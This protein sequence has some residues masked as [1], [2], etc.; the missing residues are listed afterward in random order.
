MSTNYQDAPE[1]EAEYRHMESVGQ[2]EYQKVRTNESM[3]EQQEYNIYGQE[4]KDC[5]FEELK[6][7]YEDGKDQAMQRLSTEQEEDDNLRLEEEV[8]H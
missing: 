6:M 3:N 4:Y 1:T 7:Q 8:A 5:A 2:V